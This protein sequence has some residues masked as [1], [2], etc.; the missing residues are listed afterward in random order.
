MVFSS[1]FELV[2]AKEGWEVITGWNYLLRDKFLSEA[3][4]KYV[5][6]ILLTRKWSYDIDSFF[7]TIVLPVH[8]SFI[9]LINKKVL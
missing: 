9:F 5:Y 8:C 6:E 2:Q 7:P 1:Y 3:L 4:A